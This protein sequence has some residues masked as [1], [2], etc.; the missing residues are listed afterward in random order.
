MEQLRDIFLSE[1]GN[2]KWSDI[3]PSWPDEEIVI[4]SPGHDSGTFDYFNEVVLEEKPM[5]EG[6]GVTLSEDDN[7]LV[8]GIQEDPYAIGFFGYA[9]Y[10]ANEDSLKVLAIDGGNGPVKP[11][12]ETI[13]DGTYSPLSRP[14]F[15]YINAES[16]KKPEVQ[17]FTDF[18]LSGAAAEGAELVG[19]VPLPEEEYKSQLEALQAKYK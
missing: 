15:T 2:T 19:Y 8:R 18:L 7:L 4:Y 5:R 10:V 6:E 16:L 13:Q 9:Y 14:L 11:S 1:R 3:D 12:G 17:A